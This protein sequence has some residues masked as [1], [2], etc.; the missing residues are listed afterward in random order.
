MLLRRSSGFHIWLSVGINA[1]S[2]FFSF[3]FL[4][5]LPV[6]LGIAGFWAPLAPTLG[7]MRHEENPWNSPLCHPSDVEVPSQS[8]FF[9]IRFYLFFGP[10][11]PWKLSGRDRRPLIVGGAGGQRRSSFR[12]PPSPFCIRAIDGWMFLLPLDS[13]PRLTNSLHVT[14]ETRRTHVSKNTFQ[15]TLSSWSWNFQA[16]CR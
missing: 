11:H 15:M 2:F 3:F 7:L 9:S 12:V 4:F 1:L 8:T 5:F 16:H 14:Q 10:C 6:F 13:R